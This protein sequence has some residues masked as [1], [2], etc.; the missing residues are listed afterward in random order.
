MDL[1]TDL[2]LK[3]PT[4][5][6]LICYRKCEKCLFFRNW[7]QRIYEMLLTCSLESNKE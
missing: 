5:Q 2:F 4:H 6:E 1:E 3:K 7:W